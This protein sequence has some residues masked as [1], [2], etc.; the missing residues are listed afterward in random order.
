MNSKR[1]MVIVLILALVFSISGM[2]A[3]AAKSDVDFTLSVADDLQYR[4]ENDVL[5]P[6]VI[7]TQTD[8]GFVDLEMFL[9]FDPDYL[10]CSTL[11]PEEVDGWTTRLYERPD[12]GKYGL[13]IN[14]SSPDGTRTKKDTQMEFKVKFVVKTGVAST[15]HC[16]LSLEV[17]PENVYGLNSNGE[18]N[19]SL[20]T[21]SDAKDKDLVIVETSAGQTTVA[22]N[23]DDPNFSIPTVIPNPD[24]P[25]KKEASGGCT[26]GAVIGIIFGA[27]VVFA[28]GVVV[29]F[30]LCQKRMNEDGYNVA[31]VSF[32]DIGSRLGGGFAGKKDNGRTFTQA[33][34]EYTRSTGR[35]GSIYDEE[36]ITP[37]RQTRPAPTN[38]PRSE[39]EL[40]DTSY[41]GRATDTRIGG[42]G[43]RSQMPTVTSGFDDDDDDDD[44]DG[45]PSELA[46]RGRISSRGDLT[47]EGYFGGAAR[48]ERNDDGYGAFETDDDDDTGY[49]P[50][51]RRRYR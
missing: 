9:M 38:A 26:G 24:D 18:K 15:E 14:Y 50:S 44:D 13:V 49:R 47:A 17:L 19:H 22:D 37:T 1:S 7:K 12:D 5:V 11:M 43:F 23:G 16:T 27:L 42:S 30:V 25:G 29:G 46:P 34:E 10:I 36:I 35:S 4:A 40:V 51:D 33:T 31:P 8:N 39:D 6:I 2:T 41:F 32:K 45:F 20:L 21:I 28:A 3:F 48:R